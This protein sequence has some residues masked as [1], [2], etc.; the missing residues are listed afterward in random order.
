MKALLFILLFSTIYSLDIKNA[1]EFIEKLRNDYPANETILQNGINT[2][3]EFLKHYLFY[4]I[5]SDPPQPSFSKNY[6][7]KLDFIK[8]FK[9][10]K[11]S[12]TNYFDFSN[13]FIRTV[14]KLNDLHTTPYFGIL[15]LEKYGYVCPI[16]LTTRYDKEKNIAN[17][18]GSFSFDVKYYN[19]FKNSEHVIET[20][21]KNLNTAIKTINNKDPFTFIQ[22][23][24]GF[25]L[26]NKHSTYV[27]NKLT[28]TQNNFYIPVDFDEITNFTVVYANG[29]NFTTE[30]IV[31]NKS[32][33]TND[34][35]FYENEDDNEKFV[36]YL[37]NY[38]ENFKSF[39]SNNVFASLPFKSLDDII[40]EF[41]EKN[42]VKGI[43]MFLTPLK[44][45]NKNGNNINW[46]YSYTS[47]N[48]QLVV[49]QCRV[50]EEN[51]VNVMRINNFGGVSDSDPS[52]D[53]AEKCA[54]LF[55][56]NK[57][58]IVIIFPRNGGGNPIIGYNIIRLLSPYILTRNTLRIKKDE[59][60]E[61][62][63]EA[64]NIYDLFVELNST[65]KVKGDY[66][67]DDFIKEEYGN[68]TEEWSKPFA[69]RVNQS[70]IEKIKKNLK[71]KRK[72]TEI[73]VMTD[74]F[75]LSA[76]SIFMKN[77][78]K[79]GAGIVVGYNGNPNLP[80]EIADISQSPS[81]V[82]G[83]GNYKDIYPEI[84]NN[85]VK[86]KIG[87]A[88]LTCI[89]SY[90]E[91]QE[92]YTPQEYDVQ[93]ADKRIKIYNEYDDIYYQE[94]I[95]EAIEVLDSYQE[96]CNPNHTMLVLFSD[97]CKFDDKLLHGGFKCGSDSKWDR[98]NCIPVYCDSGYY[99]NKKSNSCIK[100]PMEEEPDK[101]PANKKIH[102]KNNLWVIIIII[103]IALA[104]LIVVGIIIMYKKKLLCF[105]KQKNL[106]PDD[107]EPTTNL[108]R[109]S[110]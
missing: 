109:D 90:H 58:R 17:M 18:Y 85:I 88:G 93:I 110:Q 13:E 81:A 79:S 48:N 14:F 70:K 97:E 34:I 15:P 46:T 104:I 4:T 107:Y 67:K 66:I 38:N 87:L 45:E 40:L 54:L 24:A 99:Y 76:A 82:F 100:Y 3:L 44:T 62:F 91:F 27:F 106:I 83:V 108:I 89:A 10:I 30:Y 92:S 61:K 28:Y 98:S 2:T 26:R 19:Y 22:E 84:F 80:N 5:G 75:A 95:K 96:N 51:Q 64:Y 36:N 63:I 41:E 50:D 74:G 33:N 53:V 102:I 20:I 9:D 86:Y 59:N 35:M 77:V 31:Q 69:W 21:Q 57:Y 56:K 23:F 1:S 8:M 12:N 78:Y 7:P 71:H 105:N 47:L 32:A 16:Y 55:D 43:N 60:M 25:K 42:E 39:Y 37:N 29:D 72:P 103:V 68:K 49:F 6:F 73:V 101:E 11:T 94:F 65:N 52:L